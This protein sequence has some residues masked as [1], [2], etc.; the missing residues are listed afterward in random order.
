M[1]YF[2]MLQRREQILA[3]GAG[4]LLLIAALFTFVVTPMLTRA[5]NL[6][7]RLAAA[8]RQ[9][10]ALQTLHSDYQRQKQIIDRI[11]AQLRRQQ[12]NFAIFSHLEQVAAQTQSG[13][14][15]KIQSMN[16]V[17]SPPNTA[18]KEDSVEVN[19]E[20]VTLEQLVEYLHRV[21]SSPQ[22]LKI[23]RLQVKPARD[24]R[25]QLSVRFRVSVFSLLAAS[26]G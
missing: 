22:V 1:T 3:L 15:D 8:S 4:I 18:Y 25:Q 17:A 6:D 26:A 16:T 19:M 23:K 7:R 20:G 12:K 14:Q 2:H 10:A 24:N 9:L 13:I 11:D 5:A 21:E